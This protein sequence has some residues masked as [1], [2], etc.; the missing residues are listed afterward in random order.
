MDRHS[1]T[2]HLCAKP[3][4]PSGKR[5]PL[6]SWLEDINLMPDRH[7]GFKQHRLSS[8]LELDRSPHI[9][10]QCTRSCYIETKIQPNKLTYYFAFCVLSIKYCKHE[11]GKEQILWDTPFKIP[12]MDFYVRPPVCLTDVKTVRTKHTVCV[13]GS[14]R[15]DAHNIFLRSADGG[16]LKINVR[17]VEFP[18][19]VAEGVLLIK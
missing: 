5:P 1:T 19:G 18:P 11:H 15:E 7:S 16:A 3:I 13:S 6:K 8:G 14:A 4:Y 9:S 2:R 17:A 12:Y 10:D